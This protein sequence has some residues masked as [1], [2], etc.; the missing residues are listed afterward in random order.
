METKQ[1]QQIEALG[2]VQAFLDAHPSDGELPF[3]SARAMLDDTVSQLRALAG[4]QERG[5]DR[6]RGGVQRLRDQ[7]ALLLDRYIRPVV[8]IARAQIDPASDAGVPAELRMPKLPIGPT[9]LLAKCDAMIEV[10]RQHTAMFTAHGLPED[11]FTRFTA[12]RNELARILHERVTQVNAH[13]AARAG[14]TVQLRRGRRAI[15]RLD[16]L[17][18]AAFRGDAMTLTAWRTAKRVQQQPGGSAR[19]VAE[20]EQDEVPASVSAPQAQAA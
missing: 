5:R 19:V 12:A 7:K 1:K 16:A 8:T 13:V 14:L 3:T 6:S 18:R 17:V 10:G 9:A 4:T 2:R 11:F 15:E 20:R